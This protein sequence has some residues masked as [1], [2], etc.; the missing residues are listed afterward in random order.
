MITVDV[1]KLMPSSATRSRN[2][3]RVNYDEAAPCYMCGRP[4]DPNT[5]TYFQVINGGSHVALREPGDSGEP[6][7]DPDH[8]DAGYMGHHPFGSDCARKVRKAGAK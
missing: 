3:A 6:G 1:Y 8:T 5:A 2:E 7:H 4:V